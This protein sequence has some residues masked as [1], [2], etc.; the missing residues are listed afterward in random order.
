VN[1][2]AYGGGS[3]LVFLNGTHR[4]GAKIARMLAIHPG[5]NENP[6]RKNLDLSCVR[7]GNHVVILHWNGWEAAFSIWRK[8][9]AA[10]RQAPECAAPGITDSCCDS[11]GFAGRF[12]HTLP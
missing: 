7:C 3:F 9:H 1:E 11:I 2:A 5:G 4:A 12:P 6:P 10:T 8:N